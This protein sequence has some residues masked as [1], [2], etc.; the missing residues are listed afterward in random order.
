MSRTERTA[1][2]R[3]AFLSSLIETGGN[4]SRA[5]EFA[6]IARQRVYEWRGDDIEFAR[7]WDE[8]V[9]AGTDE[10]EEEARR[11]AFNGVDEPVFYQG[12]ECGTIRKY[13][14]TLLIFLLKGRKPDK[15]RDRVTI[16]V[17]KLDADI[18]RELALIAAGSQAGA[19][20][21]TS[22]ET[23]IH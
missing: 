2:K 10:L 19:S 1:K 21:E 5:C 13:S 15:Y 3:A 17:N 18:E 23:S 22:G 12:E 11:R 20:G 7:A 14:D 6:G 9:E 4:V 8:A 16:D